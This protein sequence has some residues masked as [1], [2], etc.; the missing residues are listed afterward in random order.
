MELAPNLINSDPTGMKLLLTDLQVALAHLDK[1]DTL[2]DPVSIL[3]VQRH[4][5]RTYDEAVALLPQLTISDD[6]CRYVQSQIALLK[7]R[8]VQLGEEF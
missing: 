7:L 1:K 2:R 4:A 3:T 8:L 6:N 5:R